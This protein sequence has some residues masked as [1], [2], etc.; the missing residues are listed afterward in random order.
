MK[1]T[2]LLSCILLI[3]IPYLQ[4]QIKY[5]V[6]ESSFILE[7]P[8]NNSKVIKMLKIGDTVLMTGWVYPFWS[9][10]K[11][12]KV[13]FMNTIFVPA[14]SELRK[15]RGDPAPATNNYQWPT[16]IKIGISIG[17]LTHLIGEPTII[18]KTETTDI[19][20]YQYVYRK[21]DEKVK[22]YYFENGVL[23]SFQE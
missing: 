11:G 2:L 3:S 17:D 18:N 15:L 14:T 13:G 23:T 22:Y 5:V 21:K 20:Y 9:V 1:K 8:D 6:Q 16:Y 7:Y 19:T 10:T 12:D 4:A